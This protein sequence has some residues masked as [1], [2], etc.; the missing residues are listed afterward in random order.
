[1]ICFAPDGSRIQVNH[2]YQGE[3]YILILVEWIYDRDGNGESRS[4][5]IITSYHSLQLF[6]TI[7]EVQ[8]GQLKRRIGFAPPRES[9]VK[10][11]TT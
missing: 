5:E 4:V 7:E 3:S 9:E 6:L 2:F 8:K 1:M 11:E 10:S